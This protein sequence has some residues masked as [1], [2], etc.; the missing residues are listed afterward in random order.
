MFRLGQVTFPSLISVCPF[1]YLLVFNKT[2]LIF[3]SVNFLV[4][5]LYE[6]IL[7][8]CSKNSSWH[9]LW[10]CF[11]LL[12]CASFS[13][14][15][16]WTENSNLEYGVVI[17]TTTNNNNYLHLQR[18]QQGSLYVLTTCSYLR[19]EYHSHFILHNSLQKRKWNTHLYTVEIT[20]KF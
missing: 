10:I 6:S 3:D 9:L 18:P 5:M 19:L 11:S 8:W 2:L 20:G 7:S 13:Y 15:L 14:H 12:M 4:M 17:I 1:I 16:G